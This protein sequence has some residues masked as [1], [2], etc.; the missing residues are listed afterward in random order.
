MCRSQRSQSFSHFSRWSWSK[1]GGG[2]PVA[3]GPF[4]FDGPTLSFSDM[5]GYDGRILV[6]LDVF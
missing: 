3:I 1:E 6:I 2:L 5:P 4:S